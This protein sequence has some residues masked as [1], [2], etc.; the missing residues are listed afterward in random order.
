MDQ[1]VL[2]R[3]S[4]VHSGVPPCRTAWGAR[5][6]HK[7][8]NMVR[9][10]TERCGNFCCLFTLW[11]SGNTAVVLLQ[12]LPVRTA[13]HCGSFRDDD[14]LKCPEQFCSLYSL[15]TC[16][17]NATLPTTIR[18]VALAMTVLRIQ[19]FF[20]CC[21]GLRMLPSKSLAGINTM[22]EHPPL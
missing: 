3:A 22:D 6:Q 18:M 11:V 19:A 7:T 10:W 2:Q 5:V 1:P 17:S 13:T 12:C 14:I 9:R 8:A 20:A 16:F 21:S 15:R 4:P